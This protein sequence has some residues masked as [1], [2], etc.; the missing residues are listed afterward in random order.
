ML[1]EQYAH[2]MESIADHIDSKYLLA[3]NSHKPVAQKTLLNS[4]YIRSAERLIKRLM[5]K[6]STAVQVR[7]GIVGDHKN[8]FNL[9]DLAFINA[10]LLEHF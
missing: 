7:K 4:P 5:G 10:S 2:T 3:D 9:D 6:P 8:Y 1:S